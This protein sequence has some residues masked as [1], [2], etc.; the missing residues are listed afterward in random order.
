MP[1]LIAVPLG[2]LVGAILGLVGAGGSIIAVPA[3]VYG[4]G[5]SPR[6]AIPA[7]LIIVGLSSI[8]AVLP[9]LR[10]GVDWTAAATVGAAGIPAAW[11]GAAVGRLLDA[12]ALLLAFAVLMVAAGVRM[13]VGGRRPVAPRT[14]ALLGIRIVRGIAVGLGV[15]FLTGM[16][17]I[18]GGFIII[19]ALTLLLGLGMATAVGTSLV[20]IVVNALAGLSATA[21]SL[22]DNWPVVAVFAAAAIIA[23]FVA[24]RFA[25]RLPDNLVKTVFA[26][27]TLLVAVFTGVSSAYALLAR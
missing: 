10:R 9:R 7:S 22:G 13:L 4:T 12:D 24:A 21:G 19:P 6:E 14:P 20:I 25:G 23:S 27:L 2:L 11:L 5:L 16:L 15:G 1:L 26:I 3:L 17:G 8:V 18:G